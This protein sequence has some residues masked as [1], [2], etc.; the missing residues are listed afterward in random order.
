MA[1]RARITKAICWAHARRKFFE[2]ADIAAAAPAQQGRP[3][4]PPIAL[5]A[6]RRIDALFDIER[7]S[8]DAIP[9]PAFALRQ[10][11]AV[12][13]VSDL[14]HW[15]RAEFSRLSRHAPVAKAMDCMLKRWDGFHPL[16][17]DGRICLSTTPPSAPFAA[18]PSAGKA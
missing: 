10:A 7:S 16:S 8:D 15:V 2:L 6:V 12:L 9:A 5:E 18:W 1:A 17:R 4:D 13:L 14:E 11:E 3:A